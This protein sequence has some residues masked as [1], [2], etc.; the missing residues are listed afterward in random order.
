M[1][2][3][4]DFREDE[5]LRREKWRDSIFSGCLVGRGEGKK[6]VGCFLLAISCKACG[7]ISV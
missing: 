6:V 5:K 2:V 3:W 7:K 1:F 4:K